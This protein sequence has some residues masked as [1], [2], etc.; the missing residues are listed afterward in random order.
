M[1]GNICIVYIF[2]IKKI[3]WRSTERTSCWICWTLGRG[4]LSHYCLIEDSSCLTVLVSLLVSWCSRCFKLVWTSGRPDHYTNSSATSI[5]SIY[6]VGIDTVWH[7]LD[8]IWKVFPE[9]QCRC[10]IEGSIHC[11]KTCIY[12]WELTVFE[13]FFSPEDVVH[14]F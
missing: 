5:C 13:L 11:S 6:A 7:H 9:C 3:R 4:M 14:V 8:A 2:K 10:H 12:C 1:I